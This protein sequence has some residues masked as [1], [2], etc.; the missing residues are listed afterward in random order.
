MPEGFSTEEKIKILDILQNLRDGVQ[1]I[2]NV[3]WEKKW[4]DS[5]T[6]QDLMVRVG[7]DVEILRKSLR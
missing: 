2:S 5:K 7:K 3:M 1:I 4:R 6:I